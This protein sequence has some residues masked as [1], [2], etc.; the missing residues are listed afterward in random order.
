MFLRVR[1]TVEVRHQTRQHDK[2]LMRRKSIQRALTDEHRVQPIDF[3]HQERFM[4]GRKV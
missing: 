2:C 4:N 3:I 1:L